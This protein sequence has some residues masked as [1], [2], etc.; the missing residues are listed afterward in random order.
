M[1]ALGRERADAFLRAAVRVGILSTPPKVRSSR[2]TGALSRLPDPYWLVSLLMFFP[3]LPVQFA[4]NRINQEVA[5]G[6]DPNSRFGAW[7]ILML[8]VGGVIIVL[9]IVGAFVDQPGSR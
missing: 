3:L 6:A 2:V 1:S 9:I 5:P 7:N 4:V 8:I